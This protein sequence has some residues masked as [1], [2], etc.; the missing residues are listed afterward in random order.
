MHERNLYG[1]MYM[2]QNV[3]KYLVS[4][5]QRILN[6]DYRIV[7]ISSE[8]QIDTIYDN[9]IQFKKI[10]TIEPFHTLGGAYLYDNSVSLKNEKKTMLKNKIV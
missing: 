2:G 5:Y 4:K 6:P 3:H 9:C 7:H 10:S 1:V 8:I